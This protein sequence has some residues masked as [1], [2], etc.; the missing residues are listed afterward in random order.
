MSTNTILRKNYRTIRFTVVQNVE[1]EITAAD[2][3]ENFV[4]EESEGEYDW[5]MPQG[6]EIW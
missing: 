6:T 5:G 2:L 4:F 3:Y 1:S